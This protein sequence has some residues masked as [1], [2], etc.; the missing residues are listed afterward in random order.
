MLFYVGG[1]EGFSDEVTSEQ[2]P[3][4]KEGGCHVLHGGEDG[5]RQTECEWV[6]EKVSSLF[7]M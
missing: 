7:G 6:K 5:S 3:K 4:R 2:R 1:Q